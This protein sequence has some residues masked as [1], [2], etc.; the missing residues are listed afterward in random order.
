MAAP[1]TFGGTITKAKV[2][3]VTIG[4]AVKG[5]VVDDTGTAVKDAEVSVRKPTGGKFTIGMTDRAGKFD[6]AFDGKAGD[7]V[8]VVVTWTDAKGTKRSLSGKTKL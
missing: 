6:F 3:T 5:T 4:P 1:L 7:E 8:E 2:G